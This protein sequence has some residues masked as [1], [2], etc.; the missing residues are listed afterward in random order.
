MPYL[1]V[2]KQD[3]LM[4]KRWSWR[5]VANN[6][7]VIADPGQGFTRRWSAKRSAMSNFPKDG[8]PRILG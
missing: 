7:K 3:R 6:G 8:E 4:L 1:E 2:Y 5:R